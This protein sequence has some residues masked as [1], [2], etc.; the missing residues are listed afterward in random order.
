M[1][2][3]DIP[4]SKK[5]AHMIAED[6]LCCAV[7]IIGLILEFGWAF[8]YTPRAFFMNALPNLALCGLYGVATA[9][10]LD[11]TG[12]PFPMYTP[13]WCVLALVLA[14]NHFLAAIF[15]PGKASADSFPLL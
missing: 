14:I 13:L 8:R 10:L 6:V 1:P 9:Y 15:Q 12:T 3:E 7:S 11:P 5:L 2:H 4:E